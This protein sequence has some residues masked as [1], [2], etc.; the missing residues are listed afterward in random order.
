MSQ[1][2]QF[3]DM[4][5]NWND[6]LGLEEAMT[7]RLRDAIRNTQHESGALRIIFNH[8]TLQRGPDGWT[9]MDRYGHI[10]LPPI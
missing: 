6:G 1:F 10:A 2:A 4:M 7:F 3:F 9:R 5:K 8:I